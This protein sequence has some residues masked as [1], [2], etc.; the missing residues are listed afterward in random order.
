VSVSQTTSGR[1]PWLTPAAWRPADIAS[2]SEWTYTFTAEERDEIAAAA[3]AVAVR[4]ATVAELTVDDFRLPIVSRHIAEWSSTLNDGRGFLLLRDFPID[5]LDERE[6]ELA[7]VGLGLQLGTPVGQDANASLLGHVRDERQ[8]RIDPTVRLY[9][10]RERQDFHTDG[11]DIVG[12]LCLHTAKSGGESRIASSPAV[13]NEMLRR[14]PDLVE[15]MYRPM[16]WDRNGEQAAG[17]QPFFSLAPFN[18]FNGAPRVFYIGWYVRDAQR[19]A[20][21]PRLTGEQVEAMA[22]IESIANDPAFHIEM[23][24]RSGDVQL[25]NNAK[26]LHAREAFVDDHDPGQR[27]HLL[28]LWLAAH[29]FESVEGFL[30]AGV[31]RNQGP[32]DDG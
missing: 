3:R 19:H 6:V 26:I 4:G 2:D 23:E 31:R 14:R 16:Y 22:L 7:Y 24:F 15:V 10:T 28:R 30:R 5:L 20:D 25:L 32:L 17:E 12:L 21:V 13:Y 18:D 29:R 11:S 9:R 27:R 8:P 1:Q